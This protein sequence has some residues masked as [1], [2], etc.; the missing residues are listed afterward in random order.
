MSI[1][2]RVRAAIEEIVGAE[3]TATASADVAPYAHDETEDLAFAPDVVAKPGSTAEVAA[4][5]RLANAER[6]PV[7]PRG[8]GT[9][10]SGG[11]LPIHGGIVLSL[12][13][14]NRILE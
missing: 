14:L 5:V 12:E 3:W 4:I 1:D 11:A 9:G 6:V 2:A 13:R 10:L 8:G 7:T